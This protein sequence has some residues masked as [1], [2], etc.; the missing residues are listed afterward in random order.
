MRCSSCEDEWFQL[1]DPNELQGD[2]IEEIPD[3]V[4]PI[5]EGSSVPVLT[6]DKVKTHSTRRAN[7]AGYMGA[8]IIGAGIF[9]SLIIAKD[10]V[11]TKYPAA[12]AFYQLTGMSVTPPGEGLVFDRVTA[13][14]GE[15]YAVTIEGSVINLT[16]EE[17]V[18]PAMQISIHNE[19]GD[20]IKKTLIQPPHNRMKAETTLPFKTTYKGEAAAADH[21]KVK[22][23]LRTEAPEMEAPKEDAH[24][25]PAAHGESHAP[26]TVSEA[27]DNNPA[28]HADAHAPQHGGAAH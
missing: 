10:K 18:L 25:E 23:V 9:A 17:Q 3:A 27:V 6:K 20:V 22:F 8:I 19:A 24:H 12:A 2:E 28:P 7:I 11:L 26:K 14:M 21:V 5:A 16:S 4:K 1:P 15:D 13:K